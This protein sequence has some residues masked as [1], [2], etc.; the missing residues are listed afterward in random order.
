MPISPYAVAKLAGEGYCRAFTHVY[1]LET[2]A[3]RYFNV[4][5]PRQ[6]PSSEYA[7]VIPK[8]ITA[9]LD[10][11]SPVINGDGDQTRDFT[12][13]DNVVQ[14]NLLAAEA[15]GAAGNTYNIATG[16]RTSLNQLMERL[17]ELTGHDVQAVHGPNRVGDVRDSLAD[18]TRAGNDLGYKP[19]IDFDQGLSNTVEHHLEMRGGTDR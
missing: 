6:D 10:D 13:V 15:D 5:G 16:Q 17:R 8:F 2:V 12:Y 11:Q 19:E 9:L 4:F 18:I 7:A 1:D 14:A 3:L